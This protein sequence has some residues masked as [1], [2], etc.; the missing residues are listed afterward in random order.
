MF[1][2]FIKIQRTGT[3]KC[4]SPDDKLHMQ[5]QSLFG[6]I[7]NTILITEVAYKVYENILVSGSLRCGVQWGWALHAAHWLWEHHQLP[8]WNRH[9]WCR[10]CAGRRQPRKPL[11]CGSVPERRISHRGVWVPICESEQMLRPQDHSRRLCG[12]LG[13]EQ[14]PC[15]GLEHTVYFINEKG[16][17]T[18]QQTSVVTWCDKHKL[19]CFLLL[20]VSKFI[21]K[22]H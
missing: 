13:Q 14:S 7:F 16:F 10:R 2:R 20:I 21:N 8:Q 19:N 1:V 11:P 17:R 5:T 22:D 4:V 18:K 6:C 12:H 9:Q 3:K 15:L